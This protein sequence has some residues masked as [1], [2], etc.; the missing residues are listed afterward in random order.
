MT[1]QLSSYI[2]WQNWNI[3]KLALNFSLS[4]NLHLWKIN[5]NQWL[6]HIQAFY[7][8][9][10]P[11]EQERINRYRYKKDANSRIL[12]R[13]ILRL[14]IGKYLDIDAHQLMFTQNAYGKPCLH[15]EIKSDLEFNISY[16][17]KF[18]LIGFA[19]L[20]SIGVDIEEIRHDPIHKSEL[21]FVMTQ[22][23]LDTL[24]KLPSIDIYQAFLRCWVRKEAIVKSLG[25]GLSIA[26][27]TLDIGFIPS[28][29]E[30]NFTISLEE[31]LINLKINDLQVSSQIFA[32]VVY[33][34]FSK[35]LEFMTL[36]PS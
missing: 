24:K 31:K 35:Q 18:I 25:T 36:L 11:D 9:L 8:T 6:T 30:I 23:E 14:L 34:G 2:R 19:K 26:P 1:K 4:N 7:S 12:G 16:S 22:T 13:G 15:N 5:K 20:T 28:S 10:S 17:D 21:E 29:E 32:S 27:N 3:N 33:S